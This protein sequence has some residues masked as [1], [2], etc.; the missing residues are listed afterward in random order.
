MA[1]RNNVPPRLATVRNMEAMTSPITIGMRREQHQD[2]RVDERAADDVVGEDRPVVVEPRP[3]ADGDAVPLEE[4]QPR[5]VQE[6]QPGEDQERSAARERRRGRGPRARWCRRREA[7]TLVGRR[8]TERLRSCYRS[9]HRAAHPPEFCST[10]AWRSSSIV[11]RASST[12][13]LPARTCCICGY[14]T[15]GAVGVENSR[16]GI[17]ALLSRVEVQLS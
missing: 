15:S 8:L 12:E 9:S 3:G 7:A 10:K 16:Y 14:C 1:P 2:R 11:L 4:R 13:V 17:S 5:R 6:R